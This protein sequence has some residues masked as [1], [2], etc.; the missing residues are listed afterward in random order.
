MHAG[1]TAHAGRAGAGA[2]AHNTRQRLKTENTHGPPS[3]LPPRGSL[4][5]SSRAACSA[6][7]PRRRPCPARAAPGRSGA[8]GSA[9]LGGRAQERRGGKDG[10]AGGPSARRL[11]GGS[12]ARAAGPPLKTTAPH[13]CLRL[14]EIL[15]LAGVARRP[16]PLQRAHRPLLR[17]AVGGGEGGT[18][19][20]ARAPRNP[21]RRGEA[22]TRKQCTA[23]AA[24]PSASPAA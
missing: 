22:P 24:Q 17:R 23:C 13:L 9:A 19:A 8:P 1:S 15:Q 3:P 4:H 14:Q 20:S 21:N 7:R 6:P 18:Q 2:A 16:L 10:A 11:G 5:R 12:A